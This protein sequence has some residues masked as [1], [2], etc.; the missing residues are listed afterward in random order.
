M[1][2]QFRDYEAEGRVLHAVDST[3]DKAVNQI[4]RV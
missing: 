3:L 4:G 1:I 2:A